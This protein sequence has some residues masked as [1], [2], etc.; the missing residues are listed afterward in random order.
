VKRA[1]APA[2]VIA[3]YAFPT[4]LDA[5]S[6]GSPPNVGLR[7]KQAAQRD[8]LEQ[9]ERPDFGLVD[10]SR[11][12]GEIVQNRIEVSRKRRKQNQP[13]FSHLDAQ[14]RGARQRRNPRQSRRR[15]RQAPRDELA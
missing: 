4:A 15:I 5:N 2:I 9:G 14:A 6:G 10:F 7:G 13:D 11:P 1:A 3:V 8:S 12:E